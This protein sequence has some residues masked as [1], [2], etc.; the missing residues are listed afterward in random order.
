MAMENAARKFD[1]SKSEDAQIVSGPEKTAEKPK[2]PEEVWSGKYWDRIK[3]ENPDPKNADAIKKD[4][5]RIISGQLEEAAQSGKLELSVLDK[6]FTD[7]DRE[8][9]FAYSEF[10]TRDKKYK[11]GP[12]KL[13]ERGTGVSAEISKEGEKII[14]LSKY[15]EKIF[16]KKEK[17]SDAFSPDAKPVGAKKAAEIL[18]SVL[19]QVFEANKEKFRGIN[20]NPKEILSKFDKKKLFGAKTK[21]F[22][23]G[24]AVGAVT[25]ASVKW[26]TGLAGGVF[27]GAASGAIAGGTWEGIKAYRGETKKHRELFA[28]K[29]ELYNKADAIGKE[30]N[31]NLREKLDKYFDLIKIEEEVGMAEGKNKVYAEILK[32]MGLNSERWQKVK[33]G[34]LKGAIMGGLGGAL[35]GIVGNYLGEYFHG[36]KEAGAAL[37]DA[38]KAIGKEAFEQIQGEATDVF[39][40]TYE[41]SVAAGLA[42]LD[43][44]E[45][46]MTAKTGD[47]A[48]NIARNLIHDL[49]TEV[50]KTGVDISYDKSQLIYAEDHLKNLISAK[51]IHPGG[52]FSLHGTDILSALGKAD[53]LS[54]LGKTDL[55]KN[56]VPNVSPDEWARVL[57]YKAELNPSNNFSETILKEAEEKATAAISANDFTEPTGS[58]AFQRSYD[59]IKDKAALKAAEKGKNSFFDDIFSTVGAAY[60]AGEGH[61]V[62]KYIKGKIK[63][64]EM[65]YIDLKEEA[66]IVEPTEAEKDNRTHV[67]PIGLDNYEYVEDPDSEF[68]ESKPEKRAEPKAEP[69]PK[70]ERVEKRFPEDPIYKY[71]AEKRFD[72][73]EGD[74]K[75]VVKTPDGYEKFES[76]KEMS[77]WFNGLPQRR[78]AWLWDQELNAKVA[79]IKLDLPEALKDFLNDKDSISSRKNLNAVVDRYVKQ[80]FGV[81]EPAISETPRKSEEKNEEVIG[82]L[83]PETQLLEYRLPKREPPEDLRYPRIDAGESEEETILRVEREE[84]MRAGD[85]RADMVRGLGEK[86]SKDKED[87]S[88]QNV[89]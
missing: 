87:N 63:K 15:R 28:R 7:P 9:I 33:K 75:Y 4:T 53:G 8:K 80:M 32:E 86:L 12:F 79:P 74:I 25:R 59:F 69:K 51:E 46:K 42:N 60:L 1:T 16:G 24:M 65:E 50:R 78:K 20:L 5:E 84:K 40:K 17:I 57:D 26:A 41:K 37:K 34:A 72:V 11:I 43:M 23:G 27:V 47:G 62:E 36:P 2:S 83:N 13:N 49:I 10:A 3:A 6:N 52:T 71:L 56:F 48:T 35:G 22:L 89:A 70:K 64:K 58:D 85:Y 81:R 67:K 21:N 44:Q 45:F 38:K 66:V 14:D 61:A 54:E 29:E 39:S 68:E 82:K 18:G 76:Y 30:K 77:G 19:G 31:I 88:K 55:A 73:K